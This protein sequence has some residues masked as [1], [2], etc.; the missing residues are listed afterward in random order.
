MHYFAAAVVPVTAIEDLEYVSV[1][2]R[3]TE[4]MAP[5]DENLKTAPYREYVEDAEA[6]AEEALAYWDSQYAGDPVK[7]GERPQGIVQ[8]LSWYQGR[9]FEREPNTGRYFS[10]SSCNPQGRWDW[11]QIGGRWTGAWSSW[12]TPEL[13]ERNREQCWLCH[14]TGQR[15]DELGRAH[16]IESPG[17]SCN[18]CRG[19]GISEKWPTQWVAHEGDVIAVSRFLEELKTDDVELQHGNP[20]EGGICTPHALVLPGLW[21]ES[22]TYVSGGPPDYGHLGKDPDWLGTLRSALE[23][24]RGSLLA[25][26]DYHS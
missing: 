23:P 19:S 12:Y 2:D 20:A 3:I 15:D 17:Y 8:A 14:G 24:H 1:K 26:V 9:K 21:L 18:G 10:R 6:E 7:E 13:D 11:W 16:R 22:Q 25:V 5:Y 4:I